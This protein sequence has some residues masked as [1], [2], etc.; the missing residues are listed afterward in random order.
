MSEQKDPESINPLAQAGAALSRRRAL[1]AAGVLVAAADVAS[2]QALP[3]RGDGSSLGAI[4][5]AAQPAN[6]VEFRARFFQ[7]GS[8][9]ENFEAI[10]YITRAAGASDADLF[11]AGSLQN[12]TTAL[13]TAYAAGS[14][15]KRT[16]DQSVHSLDVEG[17]LTVF[18][19]ASAG[20]SYGDPNSFKTGVPVARFALTLQDILSV[21][22]PGKGV[23]TLT[24]SMRQTDAD[25]LA[26]AF[27]RR[28]FGRIDSRARL[29]ASGV[30]TLVDPVTLNAVL[31]MAGNWVVE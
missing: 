1:T 17:S 3:A 29:F 9:G 22:L 16:L 10:G 14:L 19:R 2:A 12:E 20:A 11:A 5:L 13:L 8:A 28:R 15:T 24:G 30:G 18:Q 23:P 21:I 27:P 31:E 7:T 4:G 26:G 6:A 25:L